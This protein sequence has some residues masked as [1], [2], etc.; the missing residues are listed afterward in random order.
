MGEGQFGGSMGKIEACGMPQLFNHFCISK[1]D[2]KTFSAIRPLY[3]SSV[4]SQIRVYKKQR[5]DSLKLNPEKPLT[6]H[7]QKLTQKA[8][9]PNLVLWLYSPTTNTNKEVKLAN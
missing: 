7:E 9:P 5:K 4:S 2:F 6:R 3:A 8:Y 1:A